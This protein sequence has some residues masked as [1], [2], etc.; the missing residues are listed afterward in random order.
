MIF[1]WYETRLKVVCYKIRKHSGRMRI[2]ENTNMKKKFLN[3]VRKTKGKGDWVKYKILNKKAKSVVRQAKLKKCIDLY[4][5][6]GTTEG[7]SI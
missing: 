4:E 7:E 6:L 5:K 2:T 3:N 1:C